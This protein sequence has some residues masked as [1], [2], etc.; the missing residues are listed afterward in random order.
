MTVGVDITGRR[1]R[2]ID[3]CCDCLCFGFGDVRRISDISGCDGDIDGNVV[4]Y[5]DRRI[6]DISDHW[7]RHNNDIPLFCDRVADDIVNF[8]INLDDLG[9]EI[10]PILVGT[11]VFDIA[12]SIVVYP[13]RVIDGTR[14]FVVISRLRTPRRSRVCGCRCGGDTLSPSRDDTGGT[15][16]ADRNRR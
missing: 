14:A 4:D 12:V 16:I 15:Y 8:D 13:L 11:D 10:I 7:S 9:V 6:D 3:C 1:S 2:R 5:N